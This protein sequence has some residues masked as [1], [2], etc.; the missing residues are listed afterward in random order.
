M[1]D[2]SLPKSRLA[3]RSFNCVIEGLQFRE[4]VMATD[5]VTYLPD[6][7]H[8]AGADGFDNDLWAVLMLQVWLAQEQRG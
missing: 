8:L 5:L 1:Q 2:L 7:A 4:Q 3:I 6:D